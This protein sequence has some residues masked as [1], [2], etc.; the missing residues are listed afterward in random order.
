MPRQ[1]E[2]RVR[3]FRTKTSDG[4]DIAGWHIAPPRHNGQRGGENLDEL[5][6]Y[7]LLTK[8]VLLCV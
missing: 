2:K 8:P 4:I 3:N 7:D 1:D 6:D 5:M